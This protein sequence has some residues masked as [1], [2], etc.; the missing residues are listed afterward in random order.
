[1]AA[2]EAEPRAMCRCGKEASLVL[3][4]VSP[5]YAL[6]AGEPV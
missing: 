1:M 4:L 5:D 6:R 3:Y 2:G